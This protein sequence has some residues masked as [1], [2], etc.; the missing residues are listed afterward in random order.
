[1]MILRSLV[2]MTELK[3]CCITNAY[4][5]WLFHSGEQAMARGPLVKYCKLAGTLSQE[6]LCC[7]PVIG[8]GVCRC[9]RPQCL[10]FQRPTPTL[11]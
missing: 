1:M 10:S 5:Q 6:S 4:L 11:G 2:A 3:K 9:P 8:F 7:H